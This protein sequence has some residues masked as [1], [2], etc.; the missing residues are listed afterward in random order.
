[1]SLR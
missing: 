1:L